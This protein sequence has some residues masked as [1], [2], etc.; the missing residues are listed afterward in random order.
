MGDGRNWRAWSGGWRYGTPPSDWWQAKDGRWYPG[1]VARRDGRASWRGSAAEHSSPPRDRQ[2]A[3][4]LVDPPSPPEAGADA[5]SRSRSF[6]RRPRSSESGATAVP[7]VVWWA[8]DRTAAHLLDALGPPTSA[9]I[10]IDIDRER[11]AVSVRGRG[12]RRGGPTSALHG[13]GAGATPAPD[14]DAD[15]N[16]RLRF[17]T[18][19]ARHLA[20]DRRTAGTIVVAPDWRAVTTIDAPSTRQVAL[21]GRTAGTTVVAPGR[22]AVTT[23]EAA[24]GRARSFP[25]IELRCHGPGPLP[26]APPGRSPRHSP[27]GRGTRAVTPA[28][29]VGLALGVALVAIGLIQWRTVGRDP[30]PS[31]KAGA[32]QPTAAVPASEAPAP[33]SGVPATAPSPSAPAPGPVPGFT[34]GTDA[35]ATDTA[36]LPPAPADAGTM[37]TPA[38][39]GATSGGVAS[40][41]EQTLVPEDSTVQSPAPGCTSPDAETGAFPRSDGDRGA[42]TCS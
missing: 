31:A 28:V 20:S 16:S 2:A 35:G 11:D 29:R 36:A 38:D 4:L 34:G 21:D 8:P 17:D 15:S 14:D 13:A 33:I 30:D 1:A 7:D 37:A 26:A 18:G 12:R 24:P 25:E 40:M 10:G 6:G 22:R 19:P 39:A 41:A 23:I 3:V 32:E 9:A 5:A 27:S 42:N